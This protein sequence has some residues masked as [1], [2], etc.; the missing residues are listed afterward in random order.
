MS[1]RRQNRNTAKRQSKLKRR[2]TMKKIILFL[3]VYLM[4]GLVTM[5]QI[6]VPGKAA[7]TPE[8]EMVRKG[9][10]PP[11]TVFEKDKPYYSEDK[12]YYVTCQSDGN[13]VIYKVAG[14]KAIWHTNS[15]GRAVKTCVFQGDANLVL[16]DYAGKAVWNSKDD[17]KR[18]E[19]TILHAN[20]ITPP[21]TG[22][23]LTKHGLLIMQSDGN[24]V[25]YI[26]GNISSDWAVWS[27]G[28][29]EKY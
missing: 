10:F 20:P 7:E 29:F 2:K 3:C 25:I 26:F 24:L 13:F 12:R 22:Y 15:H 8:Q 23:K 21:P 14:S 9:F 4:M 11:N 6:R 19:W 28:S 1:R 17:A 27:S 18:K 5:A 16:Y